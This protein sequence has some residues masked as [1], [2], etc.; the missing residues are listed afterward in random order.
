MEENQ[1]WRAWISKNLTEDE[2][3][4]TAICLHHFLM[5]DLSMMIF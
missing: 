4:F 5:H 1:D 2:G 3:V